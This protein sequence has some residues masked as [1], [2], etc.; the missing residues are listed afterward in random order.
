MENPRSIFN[1]FI[2]VDFNAVALNFCHLQLSVK[3][4]DMIF[5]VYN[6]VEQ[7]K[8]IMVLYPVECR[9]FDDEFCGQNVDI[10]KK[11]LA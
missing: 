10:C 3:S 8:E 11:A 7:I 5:D 1:F 4:S 6:I 9:C 2:K